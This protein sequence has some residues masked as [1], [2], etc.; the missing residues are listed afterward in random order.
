MDHVAV[1]SP[2]LFAKREAELLRVVKNCEGALRG[3]CAWHGVVGNV[4]VVARECSR[5]PTS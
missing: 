4:G 3:V 2:G 5:L 1:G